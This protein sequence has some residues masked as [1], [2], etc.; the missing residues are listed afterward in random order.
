MCAYHNVMAMDA[1]AEA[2]AGSIW[3][4]TSYTFWFLVCYFGCLVPFGFIAGIH[5]TTIQRQR[6]T[7]GEKVQ[8]L[9]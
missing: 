6:L 5:S 4:Q 8:G 9:D 3:L 2:V 7:L 1:Y